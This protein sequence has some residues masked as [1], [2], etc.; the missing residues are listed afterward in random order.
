MAKSEG[1]QDPPASLREALR[2]GLSSGVCRIFAGGFG[3]E[4]PWELSPGFSLGRRYF[5]VLA[6]EGRRTMPGQSHIDCTQIQMTI[7][8]ALSGLVA[9]IVPRPRLKPGLGFQGPSGRNRLQS[10]T[11]FLGC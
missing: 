7:S 2:A 10:L 9:F 5:Y 8:S 4:G 1:V 11:G 6:L 3:P